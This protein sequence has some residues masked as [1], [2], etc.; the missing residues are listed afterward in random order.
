M[1]SFSRTLTEC[2]TGRSL[3]NFSFSGA[4][5]ARTAG[6]FSSDPA[7]TTPAADFKSERRLTVSI[8]HPPMEFR[9]SADFEFEYRIHILNSNTKQWI[10]LRR[11]A[12][13]FAGQPSG[14]C[15]SHVQTPANPG[16]TGCKCYRFRDRGR[17]A[18]VEFAPDPGRIG[19]RLWRFAPAGSAGLAAAAGPRTGPRGPRPGP[20]CLAARRRFCPKAL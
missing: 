19:P 17:R 5:C 8:V 4:A 18:A 20:D 3:P 1:A 2:V 9:I 11:G 16:R 6:L 15:M 13:K 12:N 7:A 10:F 14:V